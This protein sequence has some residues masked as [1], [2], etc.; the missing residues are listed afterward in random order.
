MAVWGREVIA[1]ESRSPRATSVAHVAFGGARRYGPFVPTER[2]FLA[3]S[4]LFAFDARVVAIDGA[5]VVL[6]R[7]AMYPE[8]GGQLGDRGSLRW[9]GTS[10][11][12]VD[13]QI[14][15][16]GVIRH[17][18]EQPPVGLGVGAS[19]SGAVD[20]RWRRERMSQHT[21]QH[22]LSA[23]VL[24]MA[25]AETVSSRLGATASTLD[26]AIEKLSDRE[27]AA[28]E[29]AVNDAVLEDR[30]VRILMPSPEELSTLPLR[31]APKVTTNIRLVEID[32]FDLSPCGGTHCVR[33]GQVGP[34]R[35]TSTERYKGGTRV[36][37]LT[38]WHALADYREK[39]GVLRDLARGFSCGPLDVPA[40]VGKLRTEVETRMKDAGAARGELV[41]LLAERILGEH[42]PDASGTTQVRVTRRDGDVGSLR[43]LAGALARRPDVVA[44]VV[45]APDEGDATVVV[46]RGAAAT[47]D[48]GGWLKARLSALGGRGGGRPERAEGRLP[49][50]VAPTDL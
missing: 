40:S 16:A 9:S 12:V 43:A 3:D 22:M 39:D 48:A 41:A 33:T 30:G 13:A 32:G 37:F 44:I 45:G 19:V 31:R 1:R 49:A 14:D 18:L 6:D 2:L 28:A 27:L 4:L 24:E 5:S 8:G 34:L 29:D 47:F 38:G 35:I 23:A 7:T 25:R 42:P 50:G 11:R 46:E 15:D 36:T 20:E 10:L 17:V 26:L 21:G